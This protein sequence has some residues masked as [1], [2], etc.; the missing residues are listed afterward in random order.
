MFMKTPL[1]IFLKILG[2]IILLL[3]ITMMGIASFVDPNTL[4]PHIVTVVQKQTGRQLS[5]KGNIRWSFFPWLG[6]KIA[7]TSLSN[8]LHFPIQTFATL[9]QIAVQIKLLPLLRKK[10]EIGKLQLHGLSVFLVRNKSGVGNWEHW[11]SESKKIA[12]QTSHKASINPIL[13][14]S[15]LT[16]SGIDIQKAQINYQD[17]QHNAPPAIYQLQL[18]SGAIVDK[19]RFPLQLQVIY[20]D[21]KA[22]QATVRLAS[23]VLVNATTQTI[24]LEA[25]KLTTQLNQVADVKKEISV[26]MPLSIQTNLH[27]NL[28]EQ[29]LQAN[30]FHAQIEGNSLFGTLSGKN[31]L[32]TPEWSGQ[33]NSPT[34]KWGQFS[35]QALTT[36]FLW[37]DQLLTIKPISAKLYQG[38]YQ[39]EL[40][41]HLQNQIPYI[42]IKSQFNNIEISELLRDLS[43]VTH[44]Q[45]AGQANLY[46]QLSSLG[47]TQE[48]LLQ[49]LNGQGQFSVQNGVL[50]G[51]DTAHWLSAARALLKQQSPEA[52]VKLDLHQTP[53]TTLQGSFTAH[54]G[55]IHNQDL[56]IQSD[57]LRILGQ[58]E[59]NLVTQQLRYQLSGQMLQ[60]D[61]SSEGLSIPIHIKGPFTAVKIRPDIEQILLK[62]VKKQVQAQFKHPLKKL[63]DSNVEI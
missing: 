5:L 45:A 41:L 62:K 22:Q 50:H 63:F 39:G 4:K 20:I 6:I 47:K 7:D 31:I 3:V 49:N 15:N 23:H 12:T 25:L 57:Q 8:P 30:A 27:V 38:Q 16:I 1:H 24:N 33:L 21:Q 51:I 19:Q 56:W 46:L 55:V 18:H 35:A 32:S 48:T 40:R 14:L 58:G 37:K 61:D 11:Q 29:S 28:A 42:D 34:F 53:F 60:S 36:E 54:H 44:L 10:I 26:Y 2:L 43:H 17:E 9:D 52:T 13:I 59:A